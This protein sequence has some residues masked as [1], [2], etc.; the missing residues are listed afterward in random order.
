MANI[1]EGGYDED[2]VQYKLKD[3]QNQRDDLLAGEGGGVSVCMFVGAVLLF[4]GLAIGFA[5]VFI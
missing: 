2:G 3:E 5:T 1:V 4:A